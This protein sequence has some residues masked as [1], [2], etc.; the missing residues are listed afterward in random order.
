MVNK[1]KP[2]VWESLSPGKAAA[3]TVLV[4]SLYLL[5]L[6][7]AW[8]A[9]KHFGFGMRPLVYA[10]LTVGLSGVALWTVAMVHLGKSLAVLPGGERLVTHGVY[11]YLRHPVYLGIDMTLLGLFLAVGSTAGM[12][13][14]FVVVLPINIIRSRLEEK[15]LLQKF[16]DAYNTYRQQT[17]F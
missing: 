3:L 7:V 13:Y 15:A 14:L 16:G 8:F 10:G 5:A 4:P 17:W 11:K 2:D 12:I 9:P 1:V 6:A